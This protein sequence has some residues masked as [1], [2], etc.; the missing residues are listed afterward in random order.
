MA[1]VENETSLFDRLAWNIII[2]V[3]LLALIS[4]YCIY[5]AALGDPSHIGSPNAAT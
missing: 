3:L 2:P 5:V 1:K 4:L